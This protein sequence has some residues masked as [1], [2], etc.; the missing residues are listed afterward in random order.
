MNRGYGRSR[1]A[2]EPYRVL[3]LCE[4]NSVRSI[5]G[6]CLAE[7]EG[8]GRLR[9]FSAGRKPAGVVHPMTLRVLQERGH[10]TSG[11][12]SKSWS[13]FLAPDAPRMDFILTVCHEFDAEDCPTWPG[14]PITARWEIE[15]PTVV[16]GSEL[17]RLAAFS[18]AY[19]ELLNRIRIFASLSFE[20]LDRLSLLRRLSEIAKG[21]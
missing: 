6:E 13:E 11:L 5:F 12:R 18:R 16:A 4:G 9:A 14:G 20:S 21:D 8:S 17:E 3:F 2:R 15:D 1:D 7:R 19:R 10:D